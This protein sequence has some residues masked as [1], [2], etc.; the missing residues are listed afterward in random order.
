[1]SGV[2]LLALLHASGRLTNPVL[3]S[4]YIPES[5]HF[6]QDSLDFPGRS[7]RQNLRS[8][9]RKGDNYLVLPSGAAYHRVSRPP[10]LLA[11][12][13]LPAVL[14][15]V[16]QR[17]SL[18]V[19][20]RGLSSYEHAGVRMN[21]VFLGVW[22]LLVPAVVLLAILLAR[23]AITLLESARSA[24]WPVSFD[25]LAPRR[26]TPLP[27]LLDQV[28]LPLSQGRSA[29]MLSRAP[30]CPPRIGRPPAWRDEPLS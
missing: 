5:P 22:I 14:V 10:G 16:Q 20:S 7:V 18:D 24:G 30:P 8:P 13:R 26:P 17:K 21:V 28:C 29:S 11:A 2:G 19:T 12:L 3:W 4:K 15:R 25:W 1:M 6:P 23:G 9:L 27:L